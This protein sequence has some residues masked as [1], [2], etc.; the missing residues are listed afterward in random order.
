LRKL[1]EVFGRL[2]EGNKIGPPGAHSSRA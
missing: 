2:L 1:R